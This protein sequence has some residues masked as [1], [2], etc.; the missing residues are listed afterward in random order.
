LSRQHRQALCRQKLY[1]QKR[2]ILMRIIITGGT[3]LI[4]RPLS[5]ALVADGHDVTVLSRNP[6]KVKDVVKGV[7]LAAWDGQTAQGW[8]HLADGA[9]AIINF[10]GEGIGDGRWSDERKQ[11]I[12]Q[13]RTLAGKAVME[14]ISAAAV[15]PKVLIQASAVGYYGTST[16][17]KQVAEGASP[18]N[19]FLSKVCFDWEASTAAAN[20]MGVRRPVLRTGIVLANEGGAFPKL[21]LPFKLFAGGPLGNGKQWLPWIHIEDEVRAIQFLLANE[22][23]DGP[24]NLCAPNPVTNSEMAKQIGEVMGRPSF[25][26]APGIAMKSVLGEMSVL[27]L[28]GQRAVPTK[29][30]AL[31]FQFKYETLAPALRDLLGKTQPSGQTGQAG[32]N[33]K[34]DSK[35]AHAQQK[36]NA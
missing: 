8:G 1:G 30:Q 7:K 23:A 24:F 20:R 28:E 17:D 6:D 19:D 16:G 3:G 26:P 32:Q 10:A 22:Q 14:A 13:S 15:K 21:L 36:V 34:T 2:T 25:M 18:G 5:A 35:D 27:V 29:L 12:R 9:D 33:G 31:S 4:G 11:K